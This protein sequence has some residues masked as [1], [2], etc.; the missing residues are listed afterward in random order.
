MR[1]VPIRFFAQNLNFEFDRKIWQT[2]LNF[3]VFWL[4]WILPAKMWQ[5]V[6]LKTPHFENQRCM[7]LTSSWSCI[8]PM[9]S[10]RPLP[11]EQS[12]GISSLPNVG[13]N[14][15]ANYPAQH[16]QFGVHLWGHWDSSGEKKCKFL[17]QSFFAQKTQTDNFLSR[18]W[19]YITTSG[20]QIHMVSSLKLNLSFQPVAVAR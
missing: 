14:F 19:S 20:T 7:L 15:S 9:C 1:E 16:Q 2:I 17:V 4:L 13:L 18:R 10:Q 3:I 6:W 8:P 12:N 11:I 5:I